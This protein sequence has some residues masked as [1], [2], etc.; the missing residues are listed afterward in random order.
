M[1]QVELAAKLG[2]GQGTIS[3]WE[4]GAPMPA[5]AVWEVA[6]AM[7]VPPWM[8]FALAEQTDARQ[9]PKGM[10]DIVRT[11]VSKPKHRTTPR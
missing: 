4:A 8:V 5:S 11:L 3:K 10:I 6:Q 1:S 7:R 2:R 9:I